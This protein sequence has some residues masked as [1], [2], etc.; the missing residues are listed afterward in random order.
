MTAH[1]L[2]IAVEAYLG[3]G[4]VLGLVFV[5]GVIDRIDPQ[6]HGAHAF[7]PLLLPGLAL[8]WPLVLARTVAKLRGVAD[9]KP[10]QRANLAAHRAAWLILAVLIPLALGL[11]WVLSAPVGA[12]TS[13][14]IGG[15][16]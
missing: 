8:L 7:R 11:A 2:V 1:A 3:V 6:S 4:L 13:V 5:F 10:S 9:P 15:A 14:R 16:P 12:P